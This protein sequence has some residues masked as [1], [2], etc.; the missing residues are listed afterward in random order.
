MNYLNF[1]LAT[2]TF[3]N[4]NNVPTTDFAN[5]G[6]VFWYLIRSISE[7]NLIDA[8]CYITAGGGSTAATEHWESGVREARTPDTT[9]SRATLPCWL[10]SY[11]PLIQSDHEFIENSFNNTSA[12]K[13]TLKA[14]SFIIEGINKPT[15]CRFIEQ[16]A[17]YIRSFRLPDTKQVQFTPAQNKSK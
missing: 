5:G 14:L 16:R 10:S 6:K 4:N 8:G 9:S 3:S 12:V 1:D 17:P 7:Y 2:I 15:I 11:L 13:I